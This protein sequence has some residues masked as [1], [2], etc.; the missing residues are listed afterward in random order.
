MLHTS[1]RRLKP[2]EL[3]EASSGMRTI[4]GC[5]LR[6]SD[7]DFDVSPTK[8][9]IRKEFTKTKQARYTFISDEATK[10]L[11]EWIAWKYRERRGA[12]VRKMT[13]IRNETDLIF[14]THKET[15]PESIYEK[16]RL[17][18]NKVLVSIN[19]GGRK[20]GAQ[21]RK[22]TLNSLRRFAKTISSDVVSTD[23]S[24]WLIGHA[25][26]SYWTKKPSEKVEIYK[27]KCMKYLTFL[28]Y[29][30]LEATGKSVEGKV[31]GLLSENAT[32]KRELE[33]LKNRPNPQMESMKKQMDEMAK[34]MYKAGILKKD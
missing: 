4:E 7:V 14:E 30:T 32:L 6:L 23:F 29:T 17:E 34:A 10:F 2:Y 28:D 3:V 24:E 22:I 9:S 13:P 15:S 33:E 20:D 8:V 27:S 5:S 18:F 1:S 12:L 21:R 19:K 16:M 11:K 31:E 25:K 26:S